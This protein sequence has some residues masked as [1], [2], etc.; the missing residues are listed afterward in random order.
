[1]PRFKNSF[2][3]TELISFL[4]TPNYALWIYEMA[5]KN[6]ISKADYMRLLVQK[7]M[8]NGGIKYGKKH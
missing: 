3:K 1:M 8:E 2:P 5:K 4:T 7:D 6:R